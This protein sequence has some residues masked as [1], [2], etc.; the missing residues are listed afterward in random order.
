MGT[1]DYDPLNKKQINNSLGLIFLLPEVVT[2]NGTLIS[3]DGCGVFDPKSN[4]MY[5]TMFAGIY[6][7]ICMGATYERIHYLTIK[8]QQPSTGYNYACFTHTIPDG[9]P[10]QTGDRLFG[11]TMNGCSKNWCPLNPAI[12]NAS[13]SEIMF[14]PIKNIPTVQ[15]SSFR[16]ITTSAAIN[17]RAH[18]NPTGLVQ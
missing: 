3:W 14:I 15:Q 5:L 13:S 10:V 11:A 17:L 6:R 18:I 12:W 16:T 2:C 4:Y 9:I 7:P 1:I 8:I